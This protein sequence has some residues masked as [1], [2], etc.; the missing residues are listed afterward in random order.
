MEEVVQ[1]QLQ[2]GTDQDTGPPR[3]AANVVL[4]RDEVLIRADEQEKSAGCLQ[5]ARKRR[6]PFP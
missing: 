2:S 3:P 6:D 1:Q 5:G 4:N